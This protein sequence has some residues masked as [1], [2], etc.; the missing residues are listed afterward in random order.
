M[1]KSQ[2]QCARVRMICVWSIMVLYMSFCICLCNI[3]SKLS[4][5]PFYA[6]MRD[7]RSVPKFTMILFSWVASIKVPQEG[8]VR[9]PWTI[10]LQSS[11]LTAALILLAFNPRWPKNYCDTSVMCIRLVHTLQTIYH[12]V[13]DPK[14]HKTSPHPNLPKH[15]ENQPR[16]SPSFI[17]ECLRWNRTCDVNSI[18]YFTNVLFCRAHTWYIWLYNGN[19]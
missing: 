14:L 7:N 18:K 4:K 1:A 2:V 19:L 11:S 13:F 9:S 15:N 3:W 10:D 16:I 8:T 6:R 17:G 5:Q 12:E